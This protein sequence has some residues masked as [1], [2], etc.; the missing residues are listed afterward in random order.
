MTL[1]E[2][3]TCELQACSALPQPTEPL[4]TPFKVLGQIKIFNISVRL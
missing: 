1:P 2:G 3:Q 4:L